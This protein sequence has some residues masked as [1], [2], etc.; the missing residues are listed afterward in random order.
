M[1]PRNVNRHRFL[2]LAL[3]RVPIIQARLFLLSTG[4]SASSRFCISSMMI[5]SGRTY[6]IF[7][8]RRLLPEPNPAKVIFLPLN[9]NFFSSCVSFSRR[10]PISEDSNNVWTAQNVCNVCDEIFSQCC[11]V[12]DNQ[13]KPSGE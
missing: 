11:C 7:N 2:S 4:D 10:I 12:A 5:T 3:S 13:N 6:L 8:P 9:E 1:L